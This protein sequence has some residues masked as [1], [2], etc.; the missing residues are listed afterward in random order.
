MAH[1]DASVTGVLV[2]TQDTRMAPR[3]ISQDALLLCFF[4]LLCDDPR[5]SLQSRL[6]CLLVQV[7]LKR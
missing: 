7:G 2:P 4:K 5:K 1:E 3:I 6:Q